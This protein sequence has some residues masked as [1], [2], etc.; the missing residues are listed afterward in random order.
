MKKYLMYLLLAGSVLPGMVQAQRTRAACMERCTGPG[1][2]ATEAR[3]QAHE[4]KMKQLQDKKAATTDPQVKKQLAEQEEEELENYLAANEK[5]C[6]S[7]CDNFS[8]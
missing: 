4:A 1:G 5:V 3:Q 6:K 2:W 7:I 8:E